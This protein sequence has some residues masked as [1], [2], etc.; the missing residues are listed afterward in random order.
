MTVATLQ[1]TTA[2]QPPATG[3]AAGPA[4]VIAQAVWEIERRLDL[5]DALW[6][7]QDVHWWPLYRLEL[8]RLIFA[9]L[10]QTQASGGASQALG[11]ALHR[12]LGDGTAPGPSPLWLVSDG[13]SFA[14]V[15]GEPLER[16][17]EPLRLAC[18]RMGRAAV[19]ID[20]GSPRPRGGSRAV[21]W[22]APLTQRAKL[23][24][25]L[26]ARLRPDR[27]HDKRVARVREA[28][29]GLLALPPLDARRF[30]AM[31]RAVLA[32][33]APLQARMQR[34]R[35]PA[36]AVVGYYDVA[37]YA[38][39]LAAARAGIPCID[40]QHGVAGEFNLAYSAW[41]PRQQGWRLLPS[42]FWTWTGDDQTLVERWALSTAGHHR[43]ICGGHPFLQAWG[44][45]SLTLDD[46][47]R[48]RLD[49]LLA[50]SA[51]RTAVLVTLQPGLCHEEALAPLLQAMQQHPGAAWWLR[52]HP[53]ALH[54]GDALHTLV[55]QSGV[56]C[57]D[58]GAAT[59]L[60]LPCLLQQAHLHATHSS[61]TFIEAEALGLDS[62]VWSAYGAELA[63]DAVARGSV[64]V[65]LD[66]TEMCA[67]IDALAST[68]SASNGQRQAGGSEAGK[69]D[70]ALAAIL[71]EIP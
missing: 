16:F 20:R 15:G 67:A 14:T 65:C 27:Q 9:S 10:V 48:T 26:G 7:D 66:G 1:V 12:S 21:R 61:S 50:I 8:Y 30:D 42:W 13:I 54:M 71:R 17:C 3:Q 37:G 46:V 25:Y 63:Q 32:L 69:T 68:R 33:A 70:Q 35:V 34:E 36:V 40:I 51:G 39:V 5:D 55:A 60:P 64:R 4:R 6:Q 41:P 59:A 47:A 28:A 52:L 23:R 2:A 56:A 19:V 22:W 24:G 31:S 57:F 11:P 29:A 18:Q 62:I 44:D 49:G 43:A 38:Y 45:G 58:I 53:M